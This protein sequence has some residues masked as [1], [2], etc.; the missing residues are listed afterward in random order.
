MH[1]SFSLNLTALSDLQVQRCIHEVD[2][3]QLCGPR[4]P[5][6]PLKL[7]KGLTNIQVLEFPGLVNNNTV[8]IMKVNMACGPVR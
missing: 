7:V 6:G 1:R 5:T 2:D 8:I 4:P 3:A